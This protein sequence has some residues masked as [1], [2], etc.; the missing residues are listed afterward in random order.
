LPHSRFDLSWLP[1]S[2]LPLKATK[3]IVKPVSSQRE[4][5]PRT[6]T[7]D[8]PCR[9]GRDHWDSGKG[10]SFVGPAPCSE[11]GLVAHKGKDRE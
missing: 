10:E 11:T 7:A 5:P 1:R 9:D 8:A 4:S 2:E 6:P 3:K